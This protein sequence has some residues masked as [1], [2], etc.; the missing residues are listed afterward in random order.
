MIKMNLT[1]LYSMTI[2]DMCEESYKEHSTLWIFDDHENY[3][4]G[5]TGKCTECMD[6]EEFLDITDILF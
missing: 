1:V 5:C 3:G 2:L 4:L 6:I